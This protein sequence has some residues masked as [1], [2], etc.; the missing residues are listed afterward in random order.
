MLSEEIACDETDGLL[1]ALWKFSDVDRMYYMFANMSSLNQW[2]RMRGFSK[3]RFSSPEL[4]R[5]RVSCSHFLSIP[6]LF[7]TFPL[8]SRSLSPTPAHFR[9]PRHLRP[10]TTCRRSGRYR[11]LGSRVPHFAIHL[12]RDLAPESTSAAVPLLRASRV[13]VS[14]FFCL[15]PAPLGDPGPRVRIRC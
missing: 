4:R 13:S 15:P 2:R 3:S 5:F 9:S 12:A 1:R 6:T 10:P 7:S 14:T 11:P 8:P